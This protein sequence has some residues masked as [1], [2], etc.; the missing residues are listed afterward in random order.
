MASLSDCPPLL[1]FRAPER[2]E[3]GFLRRLDWKRMVASTADHQHRN[4][5]PRCEMKRVRLGRVLLGVEPAEA[6]NAGS[7]P[8]LL[9]QDNRSHGGAV[10]HADGK[11]TDVRVP[12]SGVSQSVQER[13]VVAF[14]AA[15]GGSV[16][17]GVTPDCRMTLRADLIVAL[18]EIHG[19]LMHGGQEFRGVQTSPE[20]FMGGGVFKSIDPP[21]ADLLSDLKSLLDR[22]A[23][24]NGLRP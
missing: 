23:V 16:T 19:V 14:A 2:P 6:Q 21:A 18:I 4:A 5:H 7:Q 8:R 10:A 11:D 13:D 22:I 15:N 24:R 9:R 12:E 20:G 1:A 3:E 17:Y